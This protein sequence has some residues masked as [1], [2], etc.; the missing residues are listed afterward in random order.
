[1]ARKKRVRK[2][3]TDEDEW[4]QAIIDESVYSS[5][6][7]IADKDEKIQLMRDKTIIDDLMGHKVDPDRVMFVHGQK[8]RSEKD[9]W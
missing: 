9:F 2:E 6:F 3:N 1:M 4:M 8:V 5:V 7:E